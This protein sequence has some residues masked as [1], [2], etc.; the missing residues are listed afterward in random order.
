MAEQGP[1][2]DSGLYGA[3]TLYRQGT[4]AIGKVDLRGVLDAG[5]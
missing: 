1:L 4:C 3:G 2:H 5:P